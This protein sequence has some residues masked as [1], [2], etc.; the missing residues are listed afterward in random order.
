METQMSTDEEWYEEIEQVIDTDSNRRR[1]NPLECFCEFIDMLWREND[2]SGALAI[3]R[4]QAQYYRRNADDALHC[5]DAVLANPPADIIERLR[6]CGGFE[7]NHVT[8]TSITPYSHDE[9]VDWLRQFVEKMRAIYD[10][11]TAPPDEP[12]GQ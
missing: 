9:V 8:F 3:W 10:E 11:T 12:P 7:L 4:S 2:E 1:A 5:L 6:Q